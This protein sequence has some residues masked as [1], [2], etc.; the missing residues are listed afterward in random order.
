MRRRLL[1]TCDDLGYHPTINRAIVEI[2]ATGTIRAASIMPAAPHFDDALR[3]LGAAGID[4]VGVHLTIGS[5]YSRLPIRPISE[6]HRVASLVQTDGRFF[7]DIAAVSERID[8]R[9]AALE[10]RSQIERARDSGLRLTHLDGHMFCYEPDVGGP[11]LLAV[12]EALSDEYALPLRRRAAPGRAPA[13]VPATYMRWQRGDSLSERIAFY[14]TL[15]SSYDA[16]LAELIIHPATD[17]AAMAAFSKTGEYRL[18]DYEF[19]RS[20]T[21]AHLVRRHGIEVVGR[22]D[23]R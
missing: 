18:A 3:R 10:L 9:H 5:E 17:G 22:D 21:F 12:A 23:L 19:F 8:P 11:A 7:R 1:I 13:A 14:A 6:P 15:L 4:A 20:S 16:P 2:L